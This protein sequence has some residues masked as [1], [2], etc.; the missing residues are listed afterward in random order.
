MKRYLL[1]DIDSKIDSKSGEPFGN[2][3]LMKLS[4]WLKKTHGVNTEIDLIQGIPTT[5]P[6]I[7]YDKV[8]VSCLYFQN[9]PEVE[10]YVSQ[11]SKSEIEVGGSGWDIH[12]KLAYQIEHVRPDYS[13]YNLD[14]SMGFTSRGCI[15]KCKS[16]VVPFKEGRICDHAPISEF[17]HPEHDKVILLDNNFLASPKWKEN[18]E[19]IIAHDLKVSFNQ[20]LDIRLL[21]RKHVRLLE[22][23]DFQ[24]WK[25]TNRII[26]FAF[27]DLAYTPDVI[28]GINLLK[29]VGITGQDVV[30]YVLVGFNSTFKEDYERV[31]L[32]IEMG[33]DPFVMRYNQTHDRLLVHF[34]RWANRR[35]FRKLD[36]EDYDEGDSQFWIKKAFREYPEINAGYGCPQF[37]YAM[38]NSELS[39]TRDSQD[40]LL[41][42]D[43][44]TKEG[45]KKK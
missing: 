18:L 30:F 6:L 23:V 29:E 35:L 34:A 8:F 21:R 2:L 39:N 37:G 11:F 43:T 40:H 28:K 25:F 36:F 17:L 3:A 41:L 27:D 4:A 13:L 42:D 10:E 45:V 7:P 38:A 20:G 9:K 5:A 16:C 14:R 15:R 31:R 24:S 12:E 1:V 19:F 33:V 22:K 26:H 32:L 44:P